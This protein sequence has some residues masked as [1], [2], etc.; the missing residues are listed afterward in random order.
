[1]KLIV[2]FNA[3]EDTPTWSHS[4]SE[5]GEKD[6]VFQL[7][8]GEK[9]LISLRVYTPHKAQPAFS[10]WCFG[11]GDDNH[12]TEAEAKQLLFNWQAPEIEQPKI[13][14]LMN[15]KPVDYHGDP[16]PET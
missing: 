5:T 14:V 8:I 7:V 10:S 6:D 1:M 15:G 12:I 4:N 16:I 11:D 9:V 13:E 2:D 3:K